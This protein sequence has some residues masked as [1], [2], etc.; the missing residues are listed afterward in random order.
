THWQSPPRNI[1]P[2]LVSVDAPE[3][4]VT[5]V[6]IEGDPTGWPASL[7]A[8]RPPEL[9]PVA[10]PTREVVVFNRGQAPIPFP[11]TSRAPWLKV[12]PAAGEVADEQPL[13][14]EIDW[15]A[16][17]E[18]RHEGVIYIRGQDWTEVYVT[19]P[20]NKPP[21]HRGARGFVEGNGVGA[22]EAGHYSR[23]VPTPGCQ[24][25]GSPNL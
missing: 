16:L 25:Q 6:A 17:P 9:D 14:L 13:R 18:G 20:V 23:A 5:G 1:L 19:V 21:R 10:A 15:D 24:W 7:R 12:S 8:P 22:I 2:A 3:K 11:A 4:G